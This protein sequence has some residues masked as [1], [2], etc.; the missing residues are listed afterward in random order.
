[1]PDPKLLEARDRIRAVLEEFDI[2]G[3][4]VLHNRPGH[5]EV[6]TKLDPSYTKDSD[7]PPLV[8]THSYNAHSIEGDAERNAQEA[9][10]CMLHGMCQIMAT[11]GVLL[12]KLVEDI[13]EHFAE[14]N[15]APSDTPIH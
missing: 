12:F 3:H 14:Q 6:L 4:V 5:I 2:A 9:T 15:A 8:R 13:D 1:M 10:L 7:L 11:Q